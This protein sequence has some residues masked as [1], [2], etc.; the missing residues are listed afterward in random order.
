MLRDLMTSYPVTVGPNDSV[1]HAA[2]LMDDFNVGAL[3]VCNGSRIVGLVT[4]RDITVRATAVGLNP[5]LTPVHRVM[6]SPVRMCA[7]HQGVPEVLRLMSSMQIR[8][9]PVVDGDQ[10]LIGMVSLGDIA[11]RFPGGTD[12]A[13]RN[14]STPARPD[15]IPTPPPSRPQATRRSSRVYRVSGSAQASSGAGTA[16]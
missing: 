1:Q 11:E 10:Q 7:L 16:R 14:I 13:L 12:D 8:R 9:V 4:D 3:P 15:R 2:H 6:S 5:N